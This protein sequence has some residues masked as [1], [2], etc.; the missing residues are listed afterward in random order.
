MNRDAHFNAETDEWSTPPSLL[1]PL[2]DA[3]GGFDLDPCSGAE[4]KTIAQVAHTEAENGLR[5]P[6]VGK[7]W[8]NPPY[9]E[10]ADWMKKA[11][12]ESHRED[13]ECILALV[14][15]RTSTRWVQD[16]ATDSS[17]V[18]FLRGR[19]QFGD[20]D[21]SA[22]FP[23]AVVVYGNAPTEVYKTLEQRGT[24]YL[25]SD[26]RESTTQERLA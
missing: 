25:G 15:A 22:P 3:V 6:W 21:N 1:R 23:S 4:E 26:L 17:A 20:A 11:L 10:I 7:V 16:Y 24:V 8:M 2:S 13:V 12:D 18:A 5:Q 9:S 14:P 19:L